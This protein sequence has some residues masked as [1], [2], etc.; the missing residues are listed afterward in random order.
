MII[1]KLNEGSVYTLKLVTGEEII[2][3]LSEDQALGYKVSKPLVLSITAQGVAMTPFL[4]TAEIDRD[5]T[6]P[7]SAVI[8][9]ALT[10]NSTSAQYIK[11]TSSIVPASS[12]ILGKIK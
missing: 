8:A 3:R 1:E 12:G 9:T 6:I 4:F 11:G 2:T 10:D 5:I 7:K